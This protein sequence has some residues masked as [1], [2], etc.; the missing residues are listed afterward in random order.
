MFL[1]ENESDKQRS[2]HGLQRRMRSFS[3][4]SITALIAREDC[5]SEATM[6]VKPSGKVTLIGKANSNRNLG[7]GQCSLADQVARLLDTALLDICHRAYARASLEK[8]GE[9]KAARIRQ[10]RKII[11]RNRL[12]QM[13]LDVLQNPGQMPCAQ[14]RSFPCMLDGL[15]ALRAE[16]SDQ[17]SCQGPRC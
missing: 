6:Q 4:P 14:A 7:K 1:K 17:V 13:V 15:A 12:A 11:Q 16:A 9:V 8:P 10:S 2:D 5:W 3:G